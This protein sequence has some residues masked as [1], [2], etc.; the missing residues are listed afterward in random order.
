MIQQSDPQFFFQK[1]KC[2]ATYTVA[3]TQDQLVI[4]W[5]TR[6]GVP[7]ANDSGFSSSGSPNFAVVANSTSAV[8]SLL[9]S[10]YK[11]EM[12]L[13]PK[14][15]LGLYASKQQLEKGYY[16]KLDDFIP[17]QHSVLILVET[18]TPLVSA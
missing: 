17:L 16:I 7:E 11:S 5:G 12:V 3:A 13:A 6:Y 8:T 2:H 15:I 9:A 4:F 1:V 18:T 14:E 10:V